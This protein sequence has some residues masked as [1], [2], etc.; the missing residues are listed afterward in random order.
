MKKLKIRS[1]NLIH[2][3]EVFHVS[4]IVIVVTIFF[5]WLFGLGRHQTFFENGILS[6][7][8]LS[9]AFLGFITWG[10]YKG[11]K[12]EH[13]PVEPIKI[14]PG[15]PEFHLPDSVPDVG[16]DGVAGIIASI[17]LW[18]IMAIVISLLFW[19]FME[20]IVLAIPCLWACSIGFF[21]GPFGLSSKIPD[22]AGMI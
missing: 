4:L 12:L 8:V 6:L 19:L 5:V 13:V 20:V 3:R 17:L 15:A 10:L 2:A 21:S 14:K 1:Y 7:T 18:L 22:V 9:I 11:Y 16:L